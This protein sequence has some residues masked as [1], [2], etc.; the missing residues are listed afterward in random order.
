MA[1]GSV[2][3]VPGSITRS[4]G[5]GRT[6]VRCT[7][8]PSARL[9]FGR[10]AREPPT[11]P[12]SSARADGTPIALHG[13]ARARRSSSSTARPPITRPGGSPVRCSPE[14]FRV[15]AIDRRGRGASGDGRP[16]RSSASSRTWPRSSR[17]W[18]PSRAARS[19]SSAT[20]SAGG[21]ALGAALLTTSAVAARRLRGSAARRPGTAYQPPGD[22]RLA[23]ALRRGRPGA[24][25]RD[26][27]ARGRRDAG[28]RTSPTTGRTRSGRRGSPPRRRSSASSTAEASEAAGLDALGRVA[29]AG[30]PGPRRGQPRRRS[31]AATRA[32]DRSPARTAGSS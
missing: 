5:G 20:R 12:G 32:L 24:A 8:A 15:W 25:A 26:V 11:P 21:S 29:S 31:H 1:E 9:P 18:R 3:R 2:L 19:P 10:C 4:V 7:G 6:Q 22:A 28:R 30:A 17:R 16:T 27:H 14:R 23:V 13:P